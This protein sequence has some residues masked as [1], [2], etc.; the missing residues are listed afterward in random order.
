M[1]RQNL[2]SVSISDLSKI[3]DSSA[4][5]CKKA[6]LASAAR[7]TDANTN[8]KHSTHLELQPQSM[9]LTD[10]NHQ[11]F[12]SI[13]VIYEENDNLSLSHADLDSK[14]IID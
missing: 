11:N 9:S 13:K 2:K 12:Q 10:S 14:C 3:L 5:A 6:S 1:M 7:A 8:G 4:I